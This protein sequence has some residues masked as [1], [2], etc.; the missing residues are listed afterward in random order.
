MR[1][2]FSR[3]LFSDYALDF[4]GLQETMKKDYKQSF[5]FEILILVVVSFGSGFLQLVNLGEFYVVSGVTPWRF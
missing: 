2:I 3:S 5:F 1:V 4:I